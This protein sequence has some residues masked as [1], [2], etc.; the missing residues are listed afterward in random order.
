MVS[1]EGHEKWFNAKLDSDDTFILIAEL[2]NENIS[3]VGMT[4]FDLD[5]QKRIAEIS[6]NVNPTFRGQRL[7][8]KLLSESIEY[9]SNV[10]REI[11]V[12]NATIRES[13]VGSTK[14]FQRSGFIEHSRAEGFVHYSLRII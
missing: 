6:I 14:I 4:R 9:L 8:E 13:N 5:R 7:A 2:V 10:E 12:V 11:Y 3:K 1:W